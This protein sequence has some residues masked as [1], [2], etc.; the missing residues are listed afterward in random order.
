MVVLYQWILLSITICLP[1]SRNRL[2]KGF[3]SKEY[4]IDNRFQISSPHFCSFF[5]FRKS[6]R[7]GPF[8]FSS[9]SFSYLLSVFDYSSK[10]YVEEFIFDSSSYS[11]SRYLRVLNISR[12]FFCTKD[13]FPF[14]L[15]DS[16]FKN[17][18]S[19]CQFLLF[20]SIS[21]TSLM[22]NSEIWPFWDWV[23]MQSSSKAD[24]FH[25]LGR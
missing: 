25:L 2:F 19:E 8:V 1:F 11:P 24:S 4:R 13:R 15:L 12:A 6:F 20:S 21:P 23:C 10:R 3:I 7:L 16:D 17:L 9:F 5:A 18:S 14:K 22:A